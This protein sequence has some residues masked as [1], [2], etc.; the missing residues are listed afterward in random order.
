VHADA[1][2]RL[3]QMLYLDL[4]ARYTPRQVLHTAQLNLDRLEELADPV[5]AGGV[6]ECCPAHLPK[7]RPPWINVWGHQS[8]SGSM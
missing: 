2:M 4:F 7:G 1:R 3:H 8:R 5:L 6:N